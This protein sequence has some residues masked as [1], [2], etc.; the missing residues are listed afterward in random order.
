MT[1]LVMVG[2]TLVDQQSA[3]HTSKVGAAIQ[4][5]YFQGQAGDLTK[6]F[7]AKRQLQAI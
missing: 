4:A 6:V 5:L 3:R 7:K 2:L 1:L